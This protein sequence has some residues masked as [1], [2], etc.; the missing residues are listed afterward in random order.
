MLVATL[1]EVEEVLEP[2]QLK[3]RYFLLANWLIWN[4]KVDEVQH[5]I[6]KL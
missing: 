4:S 3:K 1:K 6:F 2:I 5:Y